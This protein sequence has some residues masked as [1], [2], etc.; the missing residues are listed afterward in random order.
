[1]ALL[2]LATDGQ[3]GQYLS[4]KD[5]MGQQSLMMIDIG[6]SCASLLMCVKDLSR[7]VN[8]GTYLLVHDRHV[9]Q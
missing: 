1:M 8:N 4:I 6:K 2:V 9:G 5:N 3:D 7:M